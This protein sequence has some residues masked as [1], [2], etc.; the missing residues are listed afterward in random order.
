[1]NT[2]DHDVVAPAERSE[3][4]SPKV[5]E[6]LTTGNSTANRAS[7]LIGVEVMPGA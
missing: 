6:M 7:L 3:L 4:L 1:L 5:I 2:G